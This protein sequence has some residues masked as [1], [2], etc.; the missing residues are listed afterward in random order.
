MRIICFM[1]TEAGGFRETALTC[2]GVVHKD[3]SFSFCM[4]RQGIININKGSSFFSFRKR[5]KF[6]KMAEHF[7]YNH[8]PAQLSSIHHFRVKSV[9][10]FRDNL[11]VLHLSRNTT[12][13]FG[14]LE[15]CINKFQGI[16]GKQ[17]GEFVNEDLAGEISPDKSKCLIKL[18]NASSRRTLQR[19]DIFQLYDL[20]LK[21]LLAEIE[22]NSNL[23]HF[24]F[25]PRF[26][27]K[28]IAATNFEL[29]QN[30]SLSL[31]EVDSWDCLRTNPRLTDTRNTLYPYMKDLCYTKDGSLI[32]AT[33][34]DTTCYCREKKTRNYRP[35]N[36][37]IYVF[38]GD[39]TETLH[40]IQYQ[41]YTCSQHL[42]PVNYTPVFSN[43]GNRT[44]LVMNMYDLPTNFVQV[45]KLPTA[46]NLQNMCRIVILQNFEPEHL[47]DLPLPLKLINYLHFRPEF[48]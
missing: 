4:S 30:N 21:V 39:T 14:L 2:D 47:P 32:I 1:L 10:C 37:S 15:L 34:L 38:S 13:Q 46:M 27:W 5:S 28:R 35:V 7:E 43:C 9:L 29:N 33:I 20:Q 36:C 11:V 26:S 12:S 18:P 31:V 6:A 44:A 22:L 19:N 42:C 41:R 24:C 40:C 23:C 17:W 16:F 45:Y 3:C 48:E 8:I 25:D